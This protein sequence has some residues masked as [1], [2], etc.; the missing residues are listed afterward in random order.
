MVDDQPRS[1]PAD[2]VELLLE[3]TSRRIDRRG[4]QRVVAGAL[5]LTWKASRGGFVLAATMQI[6][7]AA[8]VIALV[9]VGQ[10]AL[11]ALLG[12]GR[13]EQSIA[14][15]AVVVALLALVTAL[16][17]ATATL[18]QLQ[19]R[20]I[21]EQ[22]A[23]AVWRQVLDVTGRVALEAYES[24]RFYDQLERV[25]SNAVTRPSA[26]TSGVFGLIGGS[27]GT[28]GLL[29]TLLAIDPL[30]VP[31]LLLAGVPAIWLSRRASRLEFGFIA[32]SVPLYRAREYMRQ[33]L[34]GRDEA[35]EVRAFGS[36][37]A[38]R[39][40]H[41]QRSAHFL[42]LLGRHV[43]HRQV[44]A[45]AAVG[46]S[47]IALAA[48]LATLLWFLAVG[49]IDLA[50]AGAAALGIR[51]LSTRLTQMF[52][53]VAGLQESSVF[54]EDLDRFLGLAVVA[55][56]PATG[57]PPTLR[58]EVAVEGLWY[59][60]PGGTGAVVRDVSLRVGA[61]EVVA[62][63]GEN[64]S[65]KT[66]LAKLIAGLYTPTAGIIRWDGTD[67]AGLEPADVR[68]AVSVVFQ[69]FVRY[70]LT[71]HENIA[72]GAPSDMEDQDAVHV[73]ARKAGASSFLASLPQGFD[74]ILSKEFADG[75]ELSVGQWQRIALARALRRDAPLVI[76][77]E[78][79]SALDPR[80]EQALFADV[81]ATLEGRSAILIT[82]R[83][84]TVRTADRIYVMQR[85]RIV[86]VGSHD[87]LIAD[88]GLYSELFS[89]QA[90]AYL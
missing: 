82:H 74:T 78:P 11:N 86:E 76:L 2:P 38:L 31:V 90:R 69:D 7:G 9:V 63:I 64:G 55:D 28:V 89:M 87:S 18:Q 24:P 48:S 47:A 59:A 57:I 34:T 19:Q 46:V 25:R 33:V 1:R 58:R 6:L 85:G 5:R 65:G 15:I 36:E 70:Q 43:R 56:G 52:Q 54:L 14:S 49:R 40:R 39:A 83:Y 8:S 12:S 88:D 67:A 26:V 66:T 75:V 32:T 62:I 37:D 27:V 60:Y 23:D 80:A 50:Q 35:K 30:L 81:R 22:V 10:L 71:A 29:L 45:L 3:A 44:L 42:T 20:L 68:R 84:S 73:A 79:S 77:D 4:F 17:S 61:G 72:L 16:G 41:D 13:G 21:G 53:S 51:L